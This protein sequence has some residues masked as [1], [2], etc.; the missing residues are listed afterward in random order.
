M[1]HVT[2]IKVYDPNFQNK[3]ATKVSFCQY[4]IVEKII[5]LFIIE[6]YY[7]VKTVSCPITKNIKLI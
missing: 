4:S 3:L 7:F 2:A 5:Y 6:I 1:C